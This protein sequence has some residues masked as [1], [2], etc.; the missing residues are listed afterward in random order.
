MAYVNRCVC[1]YTRACLLIV[2]STGVF[3]ICASK[4]ACHVDQKWCPCST[5]HNHSTQIISTPQCT[6]KYKYIYEYKYNYDSNTNTITTK[7]FTQIISQYNLILLS[8]YLYEAIHVHKGR[9][10]ISLY[11]RRI[12]QLI[13]MYCNIS[14]HTCV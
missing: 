6:Y 13:S 1:M 3:S 9:S 10:V 5:D 8:I 11:H 2:S 4:A 14:V 7:H 12:T